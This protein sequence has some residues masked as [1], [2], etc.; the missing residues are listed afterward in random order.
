[1]QYVTSLYIQVNKVWGIEQIEILSQNL[2]KG[3]FQRKS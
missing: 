3:F 1:M 2:S